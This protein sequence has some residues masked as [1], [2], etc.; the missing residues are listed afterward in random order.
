MTRR[1]VS[2]SSTTSTSGAAGAARP[3]AAAGSAGATGCARGLRRAARRVAVQR[4]QRHRVVDQRDRARGEQ[5]H[6]GQAG[7]ARELRPEV[8]DHDF[9][10]AQHFVD[11]QRD[12]A[13]AALRTTTTGCALRAA[14]SAGAAPICSSAPSQKNGRLRVAERVGAASRRRPRPRRG[15]ARRTISTSVDGTATV[16]A[17]R[18]A[19]SPPASPRWSAAAPA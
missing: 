13:A 4:G 11:V 19:A 5:R 9:L 16:A 8:L 2:E 3:A 14:R 15:V 18:S 6:A 7:Q 12:R 1:T 17:R 10:V